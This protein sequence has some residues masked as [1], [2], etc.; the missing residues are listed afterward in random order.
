[1]KEAF[2]RYKQQTGHSII[3][4]DTLFIVN[5]SLPVN[6]DQ[7]NVVWNGEYSLCYRYRVTGF[8]GSRFYPLKVW[9]DANQRVQ[10]YRRDFKTWVE[11]ADVDSYAAYG[12]KSTA[13]DGEFVS[14][15][16][17]TKVNGHWHF[18]RSG[19]FSNVV[20]QNVH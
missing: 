1:M 10:N 17:A 15:T 8:A 16:V 7:L 13:L 6:K 19:S 4:G 11:T 9:Y 3:A 12:N 18:I 5:S 2:G 20:K 14:F